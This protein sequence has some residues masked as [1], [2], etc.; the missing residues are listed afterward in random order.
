MES[1]S[2]IRL[3]N[4]QLGYTLSSDLMTR[5]KMQSIRFYVSAQNPI[6]IFDYNGFTPEVG[7]RPTAAGI[8]LNVYPLSA[9]YNFGVN[10]S[11]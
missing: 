10:V 11:F 4:V 5:L 8:D 3:R 2:Y 9:I 6:T 1:G 7:G